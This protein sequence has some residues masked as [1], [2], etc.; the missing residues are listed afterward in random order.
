MT[1]LQPCVPQPG[2]PALDTNL[3][4]VG[5]ARLKTKSASDGGPGWVKW[6]RLG[7]FIFI[8]EQIRG[9]KK[10]NIFLQKKR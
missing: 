2:T 1:M 6:C 9:E 4:M 7:T 3:P 5:S 8:F 10:D